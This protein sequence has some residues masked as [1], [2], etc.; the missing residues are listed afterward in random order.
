MGKVEERRLGASWYTSLSTLM[1][2][3]SAD[4]KPEVRVESHHIH[5]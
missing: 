5:P 2:T 4:D 1:T 3:L